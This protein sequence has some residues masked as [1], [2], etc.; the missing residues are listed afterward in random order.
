[1]TIGSLSSISIGSDD[2]LAMVEE[3]VEVAVA[4]A[5]TNGEAEETTVGGPREGEF[6]VN[7][8]LTSPE[9]QI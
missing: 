8:P 2:R 7:W 9:E 3:A 4:E 5:E 6:E 1:M